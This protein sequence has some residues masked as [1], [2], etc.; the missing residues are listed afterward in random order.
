[1]TVR[2]VTK[3]DP[4][5]YVKIGRMRKFIA[6]KSWKFYWHWPRSIFSVPLLG[7]KTN[8]KSIGTTGKFVFF[9]SKRL[10]SKNGDV[11]FTVF[12][13]KKV[14]VEYKNCKLKKVD[15]NIIEFEYVAR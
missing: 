12:K 13:N 15:N 3:K 5:G 1:M 8:I 10:Y 4:A 11:L 14:T 6:V 7:S 9:N 2:Q